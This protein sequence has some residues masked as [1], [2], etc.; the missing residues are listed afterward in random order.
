MIRHWL[1]ILILGLGLFACSDSSEFEKVNYSN[2]FHDNNSKVWMLNKVMVGN[3]NY[4]PKTTEDK[5]IIIFY[6]SGKCYFQAFKN[7]AHFPGKKGEFS[8]YSEQSLISIFFKKERWDF[9]MVSLEEDKIILKPTKS[10]DLQYQLEL[11]PLPELN[12]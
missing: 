6:S 2:L 7:L 9:K 1:G 5:D 10:S 8:V 12:F 3:K 4:A 11:I